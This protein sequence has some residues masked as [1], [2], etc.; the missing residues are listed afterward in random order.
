MIKQVDWISI[1]PQLL[2]AVMLIAPWSLLGFRMNESI[3]IG[4]ICYLILSRGI[5][6]FIGQDQRKGIQLVHAGAFQKAIEHFKKSY[7]FF[8]KHEWVDQYRY[9]VLLSSS[10][11]SFREMALVNIAFC[12]SQLGN[13]EKSLEF[14][15]QALKEF[16]SSNIA[17]TALKMAETFGQS[18]LP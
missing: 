12:Y 8:K 11:I 13:S 10:K 15:A 1:I 2:V 14:Y 7:I 17:K 3:L 4:C 5:R 9:I 16:P 18:H 6:V